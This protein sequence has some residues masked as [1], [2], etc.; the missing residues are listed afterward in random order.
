MKICPKCNNNVPSKI[1]IDG[2]IRNLAHRKFC[3]DCSPFGSGNTIDLS[4]GPPKNPRTKTE[5]EKKNTTVYIRKRRLTFRI[6][7]IKYKG[8]KCEV[9]GYCKCT[10]ALEFH[11]IDPKAKLFNIAQSAYTRNW[12]DVIKELDKCVLLCANCHREVEDGLIKC[13]DLFLRYI[14]VEA[15]FTK[16]IVGS[17]LNVYKC[18]NCKKEFKTKEKDQKTCSN[19][20]SAFLRRKMDRP[21]L[22]E[23][24]KLVDEN[25]Y[26]GT[27]R[28]YGVSDNTIRSWIK[29]YEC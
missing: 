3:L 23:L 24:V 8:G 11:H 22:E 15:P 27:G 14:C 29:D 17:T 10:R 18:F 16:Q 20:C 12:E 25:G 1:Y 9:C 13:P 28:I 19:K 6:N 2:K 4:K 26:C 21:P 5:I 7:S